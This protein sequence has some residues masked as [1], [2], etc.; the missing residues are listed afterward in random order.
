MG[1]REKQDGTGRWLIDFTWLFSKAIILQ[2]SELQSLGA[3]SYSLVLGAPTSS[4][5]SSDTILHHP[6]EV[7]F[8]QK[9]LSSFQ[10]QTSKKVKDKVVHSFSKVIIMMFFY[11]LDI[12]RSLFV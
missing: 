3:A 8:L 6:S 1:S 12:H 9:Q 11:L 4:Q 2:L 10:I 7:N 5:A